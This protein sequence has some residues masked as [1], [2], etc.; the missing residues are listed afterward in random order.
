M[1][2]QIV[3]IYFSCLSHPGAPSTPPQGL[4]TDTVLSLTVNQPTNLTCRV[5]AELGVTMYMC[6]ITANTTADDVKRDFMSYLD[7]CAQCEG[8]NCP[9]IDKMVIRPDWQFYQVR[10]Y[11]AP[12]QAYAMTAVV[13]SVAPHDDGMKLLCAWGDDTPNS[14]AGYALQTLDIATPPGPNL[15]VIIGGSVGGSVGVIGLVVIIGS[16]LV[17]VWYR[18]GPRPVPPPRT[19]ASTTPKTSQTPRR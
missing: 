4:T 19:S 10:D 16:L 3:C 1:A 5:Y 7:S 14:F 2:P 9:P 11:H 12:C 18:G 13:P 17:L 15:K 6:L 8:N